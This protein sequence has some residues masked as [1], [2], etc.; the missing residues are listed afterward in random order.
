[1]NNKIKIDI[2]ITATLLLFVI[3]ANVTF[4]QAYKAE[5]VKGDVKVQIGASENWID[6]NDGMDLKTNSIISTGNNS[7]IQISNSSIK[8]TLKENSVVSVSSIKKMTLD[9]LILA[10]ALEDMINAPKKNNK[11][12]SAN[13]AVYGSEEKGDKTLISEDNN[14]GMKRLNGAMQLSENGFKE[15]S[16]VAAKETFRKYPE[17]KNNVSMRIFFANDLSALGLYEEAY[18]EFNSIKN[19]VLS[20]QQKKRWK[21]N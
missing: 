9:E 4:A 5:K 19:L 14:F 11:T 1:M 21:P 18:S 15:S 3:F 8:F 16:I 7:S 12:N 6:V 20:D 17:S 10:L 13:T 2:I